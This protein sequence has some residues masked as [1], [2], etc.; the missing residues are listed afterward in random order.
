MMSRDKHGQHKN[1]HDAVNKY[2]SARK[3]QDVL[4]MQYFCQGKKAEGK[5]LTLIS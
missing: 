1:T 5:V 4:E 3:K 2:V